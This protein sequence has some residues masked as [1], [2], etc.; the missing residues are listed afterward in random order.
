MESPSNA[1]RYILLLKAKQ[2]QNPKNCLG[3]RKD[4]KETKVAG[5]N[6]DH[7][8]RGCHHGRGG[9]WPPSSGASQ[10]L[11]SVQLFGLR[12]LP[13]IIRLGPIG[14]LLRPSLTWFGLNFMLFFLILSSI[15]VHLQQKNQNKR[16]PSLIGEIWA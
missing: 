10:T 15:Y 14:P 11:C 7:H 12:I 2:Q 5:V 6:H 13:W 9:L 8:S 1:T 4:T 3:Q 16:K